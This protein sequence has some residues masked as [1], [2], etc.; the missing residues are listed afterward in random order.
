MGQITISFLL[1]KY[2]TGVKPAPD[3]EPFD[4]DEP[5]TAISGIKCSKALES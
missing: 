5:K 3:V 2:G 4:E 1:P